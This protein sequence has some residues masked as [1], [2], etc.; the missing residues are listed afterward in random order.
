MENPKQLALEFLKQNKIGVLATANA[1]GAPHG[2]LVYYVIDN[3]FNLYFVT[4]LDTTKAKNIAQN[5]RVA[6]VVGTKDEPVTAQLQ[7]KAAHFQ[8][9]TEVKL[10]DQILAIAH[11]G[12]YH[13]PPILQIQAGKPAVFVIEVHRV[14][15]YDERIVDLPENN[16]AEFL[17]ERANT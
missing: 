5:P 17:I 16:Y 6:F 8:G 12:N 15:F 3:D 4:K 11:T 7:G 1:E 9:P 10:I 14:Q 13:W 2:T